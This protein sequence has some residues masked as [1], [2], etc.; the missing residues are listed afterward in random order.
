M[1]PLSIAAAVIGVV[2]FSGKIIAACSTYI[3]TLENAPSDLFL[4][5]AEVTSLQAIIRTLDLSHRAPDFPQ[6]GIR[7]ARA[8]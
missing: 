4:I 3:S 1:D 6:P 5:R 8:L 7:R 2:D